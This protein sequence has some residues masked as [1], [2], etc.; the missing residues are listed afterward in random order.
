[1]ATKLGLYNSAFRLIGDGSIASLSED[2]ERRRRLDEIYTDSLYYCLEQG[3]WNFA[4]RTIEASDVPSVEPTFGYAY[5]F[6]LPDDWIRTFMVSADPTFAFPLRHHEAEHGYWYAD[7]TPLYVMYSSKDAT[8]GMDLGSWPLTFTKYVEAHLAAEICDA[9]TQGASK[10]ESLR[11][12]EFRRLR[13]AQSKD[14]MNEPT[15][16]PPLGQWARSR[17]G[18]LGRTRSRWD[19]SSV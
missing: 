8:Y 17:H 7:V 1:M 10:E 18:G 13:D 3:Y 14:A 16:A 4:K 5:A 9:L 19:G 15:K 6:T 11:K 12:L 2:A